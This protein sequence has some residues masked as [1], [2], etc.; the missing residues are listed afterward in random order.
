MIPVIP[1]IQAKSVH[2]GNIEE[3]SDLAQDSE[4]SVSK[5]EVAG[6][7]MMYDDEHGTNNESVYGAEHA[8]ASSEGSEVADESASYSV[9]GE[10]VARNETMLQH[11][12]EYGTDNENMYG[13]KDAIAKSPE[14][15]KKMSITI[16]DED[17]PDYE[18]VYGTQNRTECWTDHEY[19]TGIGDFLDNEVEYGTEFVEDVSDVDHNFDFD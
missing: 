16:S 2:I 9:S 10:D 8:I 1:V 6:N 15:S 18:R 11:D 12:V 17:I 7:E 5:E 3:S 14:S 19:K 13:T 4:T